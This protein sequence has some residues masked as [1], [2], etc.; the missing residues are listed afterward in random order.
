MG[1]ASVGKVRSWRG[2]EYAGFWSKYGKE[3]FI[4]VS[5]GV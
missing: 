1:S 3:I 2:L 4:R 5:E